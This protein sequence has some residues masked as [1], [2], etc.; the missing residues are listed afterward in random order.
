MRHHG[1]RLERYDQKCFICVVKE[2]DAMVVEQKSMENAAD[3]DAGVDIFK[4]K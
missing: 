2:R 1:E 4:W 3:D